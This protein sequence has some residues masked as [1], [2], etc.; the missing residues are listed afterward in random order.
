MKLYLVLAIALIIESFGNVF[1]TIGMKQV[2]EVSLTSLPAVTS[3]IGRGA[4]NPA[5]IVGIAMLAIFFGLFLAMLSWTD[6]SVIL[7]LTTLGY[8]L[9]AVLAKWILHED[10]S[11]QRW[12]GTL[13][14]V[15]GCFFVSKSAHPPAAKVPPQ[16]IQTVEASE[17]GG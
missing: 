10:V 6:I 11:L 14:V 1:L 13:L 8:I 12:I 7:P 2:G 4:T 5:L 9:N 17:S 16:Q 15:A 3:A